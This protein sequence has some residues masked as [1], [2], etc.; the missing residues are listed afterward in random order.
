MYLRILFITFQCSPPGFAMYRL[1]APTVCAMS[2]LVQI[3]QTL[4]FPTADAYGTRDISFLSA[5]LLGHILEDN[6]KLTGSEVEID[7]QSYMLRRCQ[8]LFK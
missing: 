6:L 4:N 3:K 1:I 8:M 7:L 2:S 5:L